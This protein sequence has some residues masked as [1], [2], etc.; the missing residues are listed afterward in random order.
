MIVGTLPKNT[1]GDGLEFRES[2]D[3]LIAKLRRVAKDEL[4]GLFFF[5]VHMMKHGVHGR[6]LRTTVEF[7]GRDW[8]AMMFAKPCELT[9]DDA[10]SSDGSVAETYQNL[11]DA[12]DD[13]DV[14][15]F[16]V[17]RYSICDREDAPATTQPGHYND[18][19]ES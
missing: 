15:S 9:D 3:Q 19:E 18:E 13:G 14:R 12:F 2:V 5:T 7:L 4:V 6:F 16:H 10:P 11:L 8:G 17:P 1:L